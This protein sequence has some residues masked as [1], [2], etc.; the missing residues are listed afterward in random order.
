MDSNRTRFLLLDGPADFRTASGACGWDP[1]VQGFALARRDTPRLPKLPVPTASTIWKQAGP[2]ILDDHGQLGR[3]SDNRR[4]FECAPNGLPGGWIPVEAATDEGLDF[5]E[6]ALAPVVAPEGSTFTDLSLGGSGLAALAFAQGTTKGGVRVVHLRRRWQATC[7][8]P[9]VP[10]RIHVDAED[11]V[12]VAGETTL[13]LCAGAPL[14][15][16]YTP[17]PTRFEPLQVVPQPFA[18]QWTQPL[19]THHGLLA[20]HGHG[21]DLVLLVKGLEG[22]QRLLHRSGSTDPL[23]SF[24]VAVLPEGSPFFT[25]V[26]CLGC[27]RVLA[28]P[29]LAP[30]APRDRD[31]ALL[32]FGEDV[33][34]LPERWPRREGSA[35]RFVRHRDGQP[36]HLAPEGA[37]RLHRLAQA[38]HPDRAEATLLAPLDSGDPD[39][40]WHRMYLEARI[41]EGCAVQVQ[42]QVFDDPSRPSGAWEPQPSPLWQPLESEVPFAPCRAPRVPGRSGLFELLLQRSN[43]HSRDLRGR[44]LRLRLTLSGDGRHTPVLHALRVWFP[45]LSWQQA[46]LPELFRQQDPPDRI[47]DLGDAVLAAVA[48]E[49]D[50][51]ALRQAVDTHMAAAPD[52]LGSSLPSVRLN[53]AACFREPGDPDA[54]RERLRTAFRVPANAADV[55][56]RVFAALEGFLTP[57]EEGIV[58]SE[59]LLQPAGTPTAF[60]PMLAEM[61][62]T[63][64]P[65]AW[66]EP[67]RRAWI[68]AQGTLQPRK[69]TYGALVQGLDIITDGAVRRGQVV[70]VEVWRLRRTFGTILGLDLDDARHPLTLGTGLNGNSRVGES[71]ILA[72][73]HA[74]AFLALIAPEL[75]NLGEKRVVQTFFEKH[76]RRLMVLLHGPARA[77]RR[78]VE[79]ALPGLVPAIVQ[80]ELRESDHPFVLGL[81]P[82]LGL[83]TY[84]ESQ[85]PPG[86]AR[87]NAS[88]LGRG[89]LIQNPVA[90]SPEH[91]VP[92]A[93]ADFDGDRP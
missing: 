55:R 6:A 84:L 51:A 82:V 38:R 22:G 93:D 77:L 63:T 86:R 56:E 64:A 28:L 49:E 69:G 29:P 31:C 58:R 65:A 19:P 41:P 21:E 16:P 75:L 48:A 47:N 4:A 12:W 1:L 32:Q 52:D 91:A 39:T 60:L 14:P 37:I 42:A 34:V 80:W 53:V 40:L 78:R 44:C 30:K 9:F 46:F 62:G 15:Q 23:A 5:A 66:P 72:D 27:G 76:A 67:R 24:G 13:A 81:S 20:L 25:D 57:I 26:A 10:L 8:L 89:D 88:L 33:E 36:R 7:K 59:A 54:L 90:L 61:L 87:L 70:P 85:P 17:R 11:R 79:E 3:L 73:D 43:G 50:P 2:W 18:L 45:R 35:P 71:L 68:A 83:D 92:L 74:Q